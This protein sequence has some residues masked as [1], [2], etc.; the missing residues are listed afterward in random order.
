MFTL[1]S[2]VR[3]SECNSSGKLSAGGVINYFQDVAEMHSHSVGDKNGKCLDIAWVLNAWQI[4]VKRLPSLGERITVL[5]KPH[6][7][8]GFEAQR[9]CM[10]QD[11]S[12]EIIANAN[13]IWTLLD[14]K[15]LRPVRINPEMTAYYELEESYPMEY[16]PRRISIKDIPPEAF[17]NAGSIVVRH[18]QIDLN[19][20]MNNS[21]YATVAMDF[22]PADYCISQLRVE[23]RKAAV[24]GE[25]LN[26]RQFHQDNAVY[27]L[28]ENAD[29]EI[30]AIVLTE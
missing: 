13:S 26:V 30:L 1:E 21:Q 27:T 23:Y 25:T 20:H 6:Q 19:Q 9:N 29:A 15:N 8:K 2:T 11:E 5:T 22:L 17:Q 7:L 3:F 12:G 18:S 14:K 28:I 16:A 4:Q 10:I 24:L